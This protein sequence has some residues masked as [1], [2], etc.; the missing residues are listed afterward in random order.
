M[1][2]PVSVM[3]IGRAYGVRGLGLGV[4]VTERSDSLVQAVSFDL[5]KL[6]T[7]H[8]GSVSIVLRLSTRMK[9]NNYRNSTRLFQ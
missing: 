8:A 4:R 1:D 3:L 7:K 5:F 9:D 6:F 2:D